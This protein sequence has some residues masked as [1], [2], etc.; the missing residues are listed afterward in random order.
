V[1]LMTTE[2]LRTKVTLGSPK[3]SVL[4]LPVFFRA[5][6]RCTTWRQ[7]ARP[8]FGGEVIIHPA[9]IGPPG[10]GD[11][12]DGGNAEELGDWLRSGQRA[13]TEVIVDEQKTGR[14]RCW[15]FFLAR[16]GRA[17]LYRPV[18]DDDTNAAVNS[19]G[20][21]CGPA[22]H[23]DRGTA[24]ND[25]AARTPCRAGAR[26]PTARREI[27]TR[28]HGL[29][30]AITF[31]FQPGRLRTRRSR[32]VLVAGLRLPKQPAKRQKE[33]RKADTTRRKEVNTDGG[34]ESDR[35]SVSGMG[36]DKART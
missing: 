2:V 5:R 32:T 14:V 19:E 8:R 22:G 3:L 28:L 23:L 30:P 20:C 9:R 17:R 13:D 36:R 18:T 11:V 31:I 6:P 4:G 25:P 16:D 27:T 15:H 7:V 34:H 21:W 33:I 24:R 35:L 12:R 26:L 10:G 1:V 29:L